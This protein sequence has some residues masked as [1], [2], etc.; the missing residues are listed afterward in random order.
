MGLIG[1]HV[2]KISVYIPWFLCCWAVIQEAP[3]WSMCMV[4]WA[5]LDWYCLTGGG[6]G[7]WL[8]AAVGLANPAFVQK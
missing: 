1:A 6:R 7:L 5:L 3:A 4:W 8:V 2:M